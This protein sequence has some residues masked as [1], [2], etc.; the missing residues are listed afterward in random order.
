MNTYLKSAGKSRL[1]PMAAGSFERIDTS[2]ALPT[3]FFHYDKTIGRSRT[4]SSWHNYLPYAE[5]IDSAKFTKLNALYPEQL[6]D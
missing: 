4:E 3:Y 5:A 1:P 6:G 2:S